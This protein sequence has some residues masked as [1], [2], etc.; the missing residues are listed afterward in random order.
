MKENDIKPEMFP[1]LK[2]KDSLEKQP[3]LSRE[4]KDGFL[5]DKSEE[6]KV[7][8]SVEEEK[9]PKNEAS[10]AEDLESARKDLEERYK[11]ADSEQREQN[12]EKKKDTEKQDGS[13]FEDEKAG[14]GRNYEFE[15]KKEIKM[16]DNIT[17]F[18]PEKA[19]GLLEELI[20]DFKPVP[21]RLDIDIEIE[22]VPVGDIE[23]F[24]KKNGDGDVYKKMTIHDIP[25]EHVENIIALA[26]KGGK[27]LE[28]KELERLLMDL[29][30]NVKVLMSKTFGCD[31]D[32]ATNIGGYSVPGWGRVVDYLRKYDNNLAVFFGKR[33]A[34]GKSRLHIHV[35]EGK[36]HTYI[37][38][39]IDE[40]N[41]IN[42]NLAGV[43]KSHVGYGAG[44][45]ITGNKY[46]L[47]SLTEYFSHKP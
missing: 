36:T 20:A 16:R 46:F 19:I 9:K 18:H 17:D 29:G 1:E 21:E 8:S 15:T 42:T 47:K 39:H 23:Q 43:R 2:K 14:N 41:W 10:V 38:P 3:V 34:P 37:I 7:E 44:D 30:Y 27:N 40:F 32:A 26:K 25:K 11:E 13:F 6:D 31:Y 24:C 5:R 45:T 12:R 22:N 35:Y 28:K 33:F 4:N